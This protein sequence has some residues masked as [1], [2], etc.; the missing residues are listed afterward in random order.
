MKKKLYLLDEKMESIPSSEVKCPKSGILL[1]I[2]G[3]GESGKVI[4]WV[5]IA[6]F[7]ALLVFFRA[8]M[9]QPP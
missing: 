9:A 3:L 7:W 1:I 2:I 6:V 5:S 4:L 8:K